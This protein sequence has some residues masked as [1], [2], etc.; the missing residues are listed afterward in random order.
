MSYLREALTERVGEFIALRREIHQH[1]ELAFEEHRTAELVASKL[2]GWGY[3]VH[4]GLGGTGVVG[5]LKKGNNKRTL[6]LRAD[7][8]ALPIQEANGLPW[9]SKTPG[10]MHAC[11]HDGHTAMLLAAGIRSLPGPL[12]VPLEKEFGWDRATI[13][14][15]FTLFVLFETWL[16]PI[17]GWFVDKYG[18]GFVIF[19]GGILCGI[20]WVMK[21]GHG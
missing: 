3:A 8:D 9:A 15:A 4:R 7:M 20:G 12:V 10:L 1:P 16:V 17:E 19:V 21:L 13:Q 11:G 18:P 2:S 14:V 6:G 5:T